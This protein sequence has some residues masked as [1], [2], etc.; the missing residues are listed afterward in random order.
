MSE[1]KNISCDCV[2]KMTDKDLSIFEE[3]LNNKIN[4]LRSTSE[5]RK[6]LTKAFGRE[7]AQPSTSVNIETR[8]GV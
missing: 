1:T 3:R 2:E 5:G 4:L 8:L 7:A 6:K